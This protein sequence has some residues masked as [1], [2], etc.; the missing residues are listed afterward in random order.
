[1][2][3]ATGLFFLAGSSSMLVTGCKKADPTGTESL[4]KA[5]KYFAAGEYGSAEVEYKNTLQANP[6]EITALLHLAEIWE[7]RGGPFQAAVLFR[8][9]RN[10]NPSNAEAHLGMAKFQLAIGD[11]NSARNEV[12]EVLKATP[13]HRDAL[14]MLAK[15]SGNK[16]EIKDAEARLD[17]PEAEKD[18][19]ICLAKGILAMSRNDLDAA[20]KALA[21]SIEL[22]G[23]A[24]QPYVYKARW[25]LA[26]KET[27]AADECLKTAVKLAPIRS[28][29]RIAYASFLL[30][31]S[32]R[33][34]AVSLLQS[35]T[36]KA[37]D[38]IAA[39]RLLARV[40]LSENEHEKAR[41]LLQNVSSWDAVDFETN[42]LMAMLHLLEK[43]KDSRSKA[44]QLLENLRTSHPPNALV[45]FYL[46]RARLEEGQVDAAI[47]ALTRT[48][49]IEPDMRDA[50][51]LL[52]RIKLSQRRL[53]DVI[54]LLDPYLRNRQGDVDAALLLSEAYR[55]SRSPEKA[56]AALSGVSN[57]PN[58]NARWYLEK[59]LVAKDLGKNEESRSAFEKVEALDPANTRAAAE[60][61][62]LDT[63]AGN[64]AAALERAEKQLKVHPEDA[65]SF[66]MRATI[67]TKL[68]RED[69][70]MK[71]LNEALRLDPKL[72]AAHLMIAKMNSSAGKSAEAIK[73]LEQANADSPGSLPVLLTLVSLYEEAGRK[74]D[75]RNCYEEILKRNPQ[76]VPA[77]N[78]LAIIL[79]EFTGAD[80]ERAFQLAQQA[81]TLNPDE[82]VISDTLGWILYK[83]G[84]FQRAHRYLIEAVDKLRGDAMV[85]FHYG[86]SSLAM[87]DEQA[88]RTAFR[89]AIAADAGFTRKADAEQALARLDAPTETSDPL[90]M[91]SRLK[92][93]G[94]LE[95]AGKF[96]EAGDVYAAALATN[97]DLYPAVSRLAHLY[98]GPLDDPEKAYMYARQAA[99]MSPE[100]AAIGVILAK[101]A[102]RSGEH[103][104]ADL[105]FQ[106]SLSKIRDDTGLMSQAAWAAYS[107]GRVADAKTLMET[108]VASSKDQSERTA[109][110][111]F[112]DFQNEARAGGLI[113]KTL[114]KDPKYVPA[115]MAR[116]DLGVKKDPKAAL[117]GYEAVLKIYPKFKPASD[118]AERIRATEAKK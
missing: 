58:Q 71:D 106:N 75:V 45:E 64:H 96:R 61:V 73:Q 103:E 23:T 118:A 31:E 107:V 70:A 48:L 60:L 81:I 98:A 51:L 22:D 108:V 62:G 90:D 46:G 10:L 50:V 115:L 116:A 36:E 109:A 7:A 86:M 40:A 14:V 94:T 52:G 38:F 91:V 85:Q 117:L 15:V 56:W 105:L 69:E 47:E 97:K 92:F 89:A 111:L 68:S 33:D 11:R 112:L 77:L 44:I 41:K 16:F 32:R 63:I 66:Y 1:L 55:R 78:N 21:Q 82:P 37:P 83:R 99:E 4:Q 26:H 30:A 8:G 12:L 39:W 88:A 87:G 79:G 9:V 80:L 13:D 6:R 19:R 76:Y 84:E 72:V 104:R 27:A 65:G 2:V 28:P 54:S 110:Q 95:A 34:E 49:R 24:P 57:A 101:L 113:D 102:F 20:E 29:E 43:D 18:A 17:L 59:A 3:S 100:D 42:V 5:E 114:A 67:L 25:H 74:A 53:D 35:A 93:G